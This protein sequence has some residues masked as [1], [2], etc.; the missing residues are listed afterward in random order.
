MAVMLF[1]SR[2]ALLFPV[3]FPSLEFRQA[4]AMS[5]NIA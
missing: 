1:P 2:G 4:Q 3:V 5:R